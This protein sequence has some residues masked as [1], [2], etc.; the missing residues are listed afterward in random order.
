MQSYN[1]AIP[2]C[3]FSRLYSMVAKHVNK[4]KSR[5]KTSVLAINALLHSLATLTATFCAV[6]FYRYL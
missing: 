2:G 6:V 3:T 5:Q 1:P 4:E